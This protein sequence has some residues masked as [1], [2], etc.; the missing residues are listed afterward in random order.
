MG[1]CSHGSPRR[2]DSPIVIA[3]PS[4]N[5]SLENADYL[6]KILI[7]GDSGVGKS[8]ILVRYVDQTFSTAPVTL[9]VDFKEKTL[10]HD[11]STFKLRIYDT[12]GQE[13]FS[14]MTSSFY[15]GASAIILVYDV[16]EP[17]SFEHISSW[18]SSSERYARKGVPYI[19]VGNKMD[20]VTKDEPTI[21]QQKAKFLAD[22]KNLPYFEVS[23]KTNRC[24]D[25]LFLKTVMAYKEWKDEEDLMY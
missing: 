16:T 14:S 25:D 8:S 1:N 22:K 13:K 10:Q 21:S 3:N 6:C 2:R 23:A 12:A 9:G 24:I 11:E 20:L 17:E 5:Q 15:R 19:I 18:Y 4:L 7:I